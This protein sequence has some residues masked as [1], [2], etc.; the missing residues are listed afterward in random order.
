[1]ISVYKGF[2]LVANREKTKAGIYRTFYSAKQNSTS[3]ILAE[4][5]ADISIQDAMEELKG[6]V[7]SY[8]NQTGAK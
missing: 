7:D 5:N 6:D 8:L 4:D 3:M 1:M 2:T